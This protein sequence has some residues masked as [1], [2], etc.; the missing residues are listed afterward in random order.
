MVEANPYIH[1]CW[2]ITNEI[3]ELTEQL[4]KENFDLVIDLHNN[5]RSFRLK[6]ALRV[7]SRSFKKLNFQK[8]MMVNLKLNMLPDEHIVDRYMKTV[9]HLGVLNDGLG[10]DYFIPEEKTIALASLPEFLRKG[11][12]A[13]AIGAQHATKRMTDE[14]LAEICLKLHHPIVLLGGKEDEER[15]RTLAEL[16]PERIYNACGLYDLHGSASLL[17]KAR[18]LITH[19]TGLMHIAAAFRKKIVSV[20]GNTIPEFGMYPYLSGEHAQHII[21]ENKGLDCRPCS[22]IGYRKC[23]KKHFRCMNDIRAEMIIEACERLLS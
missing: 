5:L 9:A 3:D 14:K 11:Y 4:K 8:W 12:V 17:K 13:I 16:D 20:W 22:K 23:P 15:G 2:Y 18:M 7:S 6:R 21:I 1:Q 19:D 10:L